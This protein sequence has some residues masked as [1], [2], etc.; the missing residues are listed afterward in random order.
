MIRPSP[1]FT[2]NV[3]WM[4]ISMFSLQ[5]N[6]WTCPWLFTTTT[7]KC[8]R[9][10]TL[11]RHNRAESS[12]VSK[13][14][15]ETYFACL[16]IYNFTLQMWLNLCEN[17]V[18]WINS[19]HFKVYF[20]PFTRLSQFE[21]MATYLL[22]TFDMP[23]Q[24]HCVVIRRSSSVTDTFKKG[25]MYSLFIECNGWTSVQHCLYNFLI[26]W[27]AFVVL[28]VVM[29]CYR[30]GS[31]FIFR[32]LA[33]L[34]YLQSLW[35]DSVR[36]NQNYWIFTETRIEFKYHLHNHWFSNGSLTKPSYL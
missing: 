30:L 3:S 17:N 12:R 27:A 7:T 18:I 14:Q 22:L 10:Y 34:F 19:W 9:W 33:Y 15:S 5:Y 29:L 21:I 1:C 8:I 36:K 6:E 24:C 20:S 32:S 23:V 16:Q 25:V 13:D 31:W 11:L 26:N 2:V 28:N 4:L 35:W